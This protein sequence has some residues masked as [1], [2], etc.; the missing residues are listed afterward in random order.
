[1]A[2]GYLK[3]CVTCG[4]SIYLK[5]D[6]DGVWRPYESWWSGKVR[7]GEWAL[8]DCAPVRILTNTWT[9]SPVLT[10]QPV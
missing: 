6:Y 8:H 9:E 1:M 7:D 2:N 3:K 10:E 4:R 5:Y